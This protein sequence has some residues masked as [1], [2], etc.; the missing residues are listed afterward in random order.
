MWKSAIKFNVADVSVVF[1]QQSETATKKKAI[2]KN[3]YLS[4]YKDAVFRISIGFNSINYLI[5]YI[6]LIAGL[7]LTQFVRAGIPKTRTVTYIVY[8]LGLLISRNLR[9]ISQIYVMQRLGPVFT[10]V[11]VSSTNRNLSP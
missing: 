6:R 8:K 1:L 2:I 11:V 3:L 4:K 10:T 9:G 7:I 5:Q